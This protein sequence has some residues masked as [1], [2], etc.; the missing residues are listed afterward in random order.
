MEVG[1]TLSPN[2]WSQS[3]RRADRLGGQGKREKDQRCARRK[4]RKDGQDRILSRSCLQIQ[5]APGSHRFHSQVMLI[6]TFTAFQVRFYHL[7]AK[8]LPFQWYK[9]RVIPE[10]LRK[11][12]L[13]FKLTQGMGLLKGA[14]QMKVFIFINVFSSMFIYALGNRKKSVLNL[15]LSINNTQ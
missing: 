7:Q 15:M 11:P 4:G 14:I 9:I 3:D 12:K 2:W 8:E 1:P 10:K 6:N 13:I 5:M